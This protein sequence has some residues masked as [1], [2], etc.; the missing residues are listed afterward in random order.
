MKEVACED[1][2]SCDTDQI[3]FKAHLSRWMAATTK[4]APFTAAAIMP[5][6]QASANAAIKTC[7]GGSDGNQCGMKWTTQTFD[8]TVGVGQ[9]MSVLQVVQA[10]LIAG[11]AGPVTLNNGGTSQNDPSAGGS[12]SQ[13]VALNA[14]TTG[15]KA[16]AA[17]L[18]TMILGVM[19]GGSW[20]MGTK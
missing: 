13:T 1:N 14:I 3:S 15:D 8:G 9:Q 5:L 17:I 12:Q 18:T 6:L 4:V 16:G 10:N 11:V 20:W 7:S 2:N 19:L